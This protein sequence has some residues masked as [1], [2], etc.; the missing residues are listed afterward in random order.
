MFQ[1]S[2]KKLILNGLG[3]H[4]GKIDYTKNPDL[5]DIAKSF[6]QGVFMLGISD[7]KLV[8]TGGLMPVSNDV[9][10]L[11]R[12]SV[13][14]H[15]RR[16]GI[17]AA[18]VKILLSTANEIGFNKIVLETTSTWKNVINFW[19]SCGFKQTHIEGDDT[20]FEYIIK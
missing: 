17:G 4:W 15:F 14:S 11:V 5:N 16:K 2:A 3:E 19:L 7:K 13:A 1:N 6:K 18:L 12:L 8:A 10:E 9:A 20:F